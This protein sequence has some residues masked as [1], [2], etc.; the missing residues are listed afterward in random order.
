MEEF[1][2]FINKIISQRQKQ[3]NDSSSNRGM[4]FYLWFD[5]IASQLRFNLISDTNEKLPFNCKLQFVED[6]LD[7]INDFINSPFHN[8]IPIEGI[9]D[10]S[11]EE[12]ALKIFKVHLNRQ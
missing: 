6:P 4:Y 5:W 1:N 9:D 7:I 8:G 2:K 3:I 10:K 12:P 11:E